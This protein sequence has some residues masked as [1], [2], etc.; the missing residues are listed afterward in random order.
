MKKI[1]KLLLCSALS[2]SMTL[3]SVVFASAEETLGLDV[4]K[5]TKEEIYNYIQQKNINLDF[6]TQYSEESST[7]QPYAPGKLTDET[8]NSALDTLNLMRYIAGISDVELSDTYNQFSQAGSLISAINGKISY[9][10]AQPEGMSDE[11]YNKGYGG[12]NSGS[13]SCSDYS[14]L[15]RTI[16]DEWMADSSNIKTVENRRWILN[17]NMKATGF[18]QVGIY[19][20]M[21]I[22]DSMYDN[23]ENLLSTAKVAWPAQVTPIEYFDEESPW[24]LTIG[25]YI[26]D[27]SDVTVKVTCKNTNEEWNLTPGKSSKGYLYVDNNIYGE[28]GCIIFRPSGFSCEDGSVY[29]VTA[30]GE[31]GTVSYDVEFFKLTS[32]SQKLVTFDAD[33]G[34]ENVVKSVDVDEQ[35]N[36]TPEA[37]K[38]EGYTFV[39][40][41]KDTDDITTE[42]KS[43]ATYDQD[44]TYK[45]K[46][47]HVDMLGAQVKKVVDDKSGIRFGTKIYNDG[48][49]IV[50][51]GTI[52]IP[53]SLIPEGEVLTLD[54]PQIAQSVGNVNYEVNEEKN[55]VTYLGTLVG[56]PRAQF[57]KAITASSY[58]IYKDKAGNEY[59]VYAPYKNGSTSINQLL[60][61]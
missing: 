16:V 54:T 30:T 7:T 28:Q 50:E 33:N 41:Y 10:P 60:A 59:I 25:S 3:T 49:E 19:K 36:Y 4:E 22:N 51:K 34:T 37:P 29:N 57:D 43:G 46:W 14:N 44:T 21:Y 55:Y 20:T 24:S 9:Y 39:G 42:Y 12:C 40:W 26:S 45:A 6:E 15:N 5:H 35:L 61:K 47:A 58:V 38:K 17:P 11:L 8:L 53:T 18:G 2:F 32:D 23:D 13:I 31:F 27:S 48:D 52:I 56:I 1:A